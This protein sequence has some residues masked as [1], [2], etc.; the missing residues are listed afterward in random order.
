[1]NNTTP[2][3]DFPNRWQEA[4][5][6]MQREW[7]RLHREIAELRS[8]RDQLS[9]VLIALLHEDVRLNEEEILGQ[10]GREKPLREFLQELRAEFVEG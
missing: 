5:D 6:E 4:L 10:I 2:L 1:M 7:D 3:T 9:K 8:E